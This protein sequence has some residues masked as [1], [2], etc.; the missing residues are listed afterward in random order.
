[1]FIILFMYRIMKN[2][3]NDKPLEVNKSTVLNDA[4]FR[5]IRNTLV[6]ICFN[7]ASIDELETFNV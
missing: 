4:K 2:V 7:R 6:D 3:A 1:M 5:I